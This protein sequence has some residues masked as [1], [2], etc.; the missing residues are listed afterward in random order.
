MKVEIFTLCDAA[1]A[2]AG[3]KLNILG[4]FDHLWSR[5]VPMKYPICALA[6]KVRF[7]RG[8]EGQKRLTISFIDAD[9]K[10]VMPTLNFPINVQMPLNE[11]SATLPI[12]MIIQQLNLPHFGEYSIGLAIDGRQEATIPLFVREAPLI[13]PFPP[14]QPQPPA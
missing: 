8:E 1:T 7:E 9:G 6:A 13:P 10:S 5:S 12:S 4:S 11:S 14:T 3:G 2:D